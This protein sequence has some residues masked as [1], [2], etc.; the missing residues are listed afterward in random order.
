MQKIIK[1]RKNID[2]VFVADMQKNSKLPSRHG[3]L[4]SVDK[5]LKVSQGEPKMAIEEDEVVLS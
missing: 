1:P 4:V 2:S 5:T 3:T